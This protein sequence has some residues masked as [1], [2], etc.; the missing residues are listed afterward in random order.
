M[1]VFVDQR[2]E[3]NVKH[4]VVQRMAQATLVGTLV[5]GSLG[6][7]GCSRTEMSITQSRPPNVTYTTRGT[8]E[9]LPG[10]SP[11]AEF[12][13]HHEPIDHFENVDGSKGMNSMTM[14][15]P[16]AKGLSIAGLKV[17]DVVELDFGVWYKAGTKSV[18]AFEMTRV[19]KLPEGTKLNFGK[20]APTLGG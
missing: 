14:P 1:F 15:L 16:I 5:C 11:A 2:L 9:M 3:K 8:I 7:F 6:M 17:G 4:T 18:E 12:V 10:G 19:K 20:A 13:V